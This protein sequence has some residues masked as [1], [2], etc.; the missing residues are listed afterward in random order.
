MVSR[1][2][3]LIVALT[4]LLSAPVVL[5]QDEHREP[6][7]PPSPA[8]ETTQADTS[9]QTPKRIRVGGSV[10]SAMLIHQVAPVYPS[11]AKAAH[12]SGTVML[13]AII[14]TDGTVQNLQFVSGPPLLMKSAMDAVQQWIYKPTLLKGEPV[15]V[16][17]TISV[18]YTLGD[19]NSGSKPAEIEGVAIDCPDDGLVRV[20]VSPKV[21]AARILEKVEP[22]YPEEAKK[23]GIEGTVLFHAI[24]AK[25]GTVEELTLEDGDPILAKA[26]EEA[27]KQWRY[28]VT[29][30]VGHVNRTARMAEVDTAIVVE[31]KLLR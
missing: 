2:I 9:S 3:A 28:A 12:I 11:T 25:D 21:Q 26:A 31:F 16:D 17:T 5:C 8:S 30:Y 10:A 15:A 7:P 27:V 4:T 19:N 23:A 14:G 13:H 29:P 6:V 1:R 20:F 18:V 24:I 22:V